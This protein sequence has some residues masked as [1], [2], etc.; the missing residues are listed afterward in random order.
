MCFTG[1]TGFEEWYLEIKLLIA[2]EVRAQL[3]FETIGK[4]DGS[5]SDFEN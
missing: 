2:W 4:N 3:G 1:Y 5:E